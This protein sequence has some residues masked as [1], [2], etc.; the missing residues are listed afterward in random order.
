MACVLAVL[1]KHVQVDEVTGD[2]LFRAI[3]ELLTNVRQHSHANRVE[4]SSSVGADGSIT[5]TVKDDGIGLPPGGHRRSALETGAV[6]LSSID[7]RLREIGAHMEIESDNGVCAR[8]VLPAH[9][10]AA[11]RDGPTRS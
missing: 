7:L 6:G 10:V 2:I 8:L 4:V 1:P 3:C 9:I 11:S 5:L